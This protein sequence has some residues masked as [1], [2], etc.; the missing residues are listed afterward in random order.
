VSKDFKQQ[1]VFSSSPWQ[2]CH[3]IMEYFF[4][5]I[6]NKPRLVTVAWS[7][8]MDEGIVGQPLQLELGHIWLGHIAT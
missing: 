3:S 8:H 1:F 5:D 4:W 6:S 2:E 7:K